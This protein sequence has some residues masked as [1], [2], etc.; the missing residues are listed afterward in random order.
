[1]SR[2][3]VGR[4]RDCPLLQ[5]VER[6]CVDAPVKIDLFGA[7]AD[8]ELSCNHPDEPSIPRSQLEADV[9]PDACPLRAEVLL[10]EA[11]S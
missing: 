5:R 3:I 2:L 10:I 1:M 4:C 6:R 11:A 7:Y 9:L 8:A